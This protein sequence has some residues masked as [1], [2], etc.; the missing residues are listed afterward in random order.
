MQFSNKPITLDAFKAINATHAAPQMSSKYSFIPTTAA[1]AVLAD[2]G[3]FPTSASETRARASH[4]AGFQTHALRLQNESFV[5]EFKVGSTIPQLALRNSHAGS[6]AFVLDLA[7]LE[8][9]CTNGLMASIGGKEQIRVL[10]RNFDA[11]G[12]EAALRELCANFAQVMEC[13][14]RWRLLHISEAQA[15]EFAREAILLRWDGEQYAIDAKTMLQPQRYE[16]REL[17]LWNVYNVL[18]EK[19]LKGGVD[20][21]HRNREGLLKL[22]AARPINNIRK[23]VRFNKTLWQLAA[24]VEEENQ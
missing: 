12:F 4:K 1:L 20:I 2:H 7:L 18:Q 9:R 14:E 13:V 19:L 16:E 22:R 3:W 5:T 24:R 6:S 8:L 10:H 15:R 17:T 21:V 11:A 23:D